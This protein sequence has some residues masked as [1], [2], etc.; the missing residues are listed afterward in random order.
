MM[1]SRSLVFLPE[2]W[3]RPMHNL[4]PVAH[5]SRGFFIKTATARPAPALSATT[6]K[7]SFA[8]EQRIGLSFNRRS[9]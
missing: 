7:R 6:A 3:L 8:G 9:V 4:A 2:P 5:G 1:R